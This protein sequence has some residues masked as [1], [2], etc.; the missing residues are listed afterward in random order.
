MPSAQIVGPKPGELLLELEP[1]LL[2]QLRLVLLAAVDVNVFPHP[3]ELPDGCQLVADRQ[4]DFGHP[5]VE[6]DCVGQVAVDSAQPVLV[7]VGVD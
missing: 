6:G 4:H 1:L 5:V 7:A 3:K 2:Q